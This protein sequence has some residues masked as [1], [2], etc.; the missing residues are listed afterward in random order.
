MKFRYLFVVLSV[1]SVLAGCSAS[2]LFLVNSI[3]RVGDYSVQQD[4]SYAPE[5][6]N[7]LDLYKPDQTSRGTIIFF[8]GGCWGACQTLPKQHYRFI[9]QTM[10]QNGYSVVIPD[11]RLYPQVKFQQIMADATA[12]VEWTKQTLLS[13]DNTSRPLILMGHSAGAHIAAMLTANE[14]YLGPELHQNISAFVGLAGPYDFLFD[15]PYQYEL[16]SELSYLETQPSHFVDGSEPPML[17]LYGKE[18]KKVHLR[19]IINMTR[20]IELKNGQVQTQLYDEVNHTQIVAALSIPLRNRFKVNEDIIN[21]L[22]QL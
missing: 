2:A 15:Q 20:A 9:A 14:N 12:V 22:E 7:K 6:V 5:T 17:L 13:A 19:N 18:D 21:F 3:A 8:Y 1:C 11:Y 16:F 4:I 10:A